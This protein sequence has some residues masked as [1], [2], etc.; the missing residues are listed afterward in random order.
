MSGRRQ[1]EA[2][3]LGERGACDPAVVV[4]E[5]LFAVEELGEAAVIDA[6]PRRLGLVILV[7]ELEPLGDDPSVGTGAGPGPLHKLR[8]GGGRAAHGA[9]GP[10]GPRVVRETGAFGSLHFSPVSLVVAHEPA[11]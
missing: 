7:K 10:A 3:D 1:L 9:L 8:D 11:G 2:R 6:I 4:V 5:V